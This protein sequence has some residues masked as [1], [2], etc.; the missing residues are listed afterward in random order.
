MNLKC[1]TKQI[2]AATVALF[3]LCAASR[4][5]A[6]TV[7]VTNNNDSGAGSLRQ[8]IASAASGDTIIFAANVTGTIT[9]NSGE[10]LVDKALTINGPGAATLG[11]SGNATSRIFSLTSPVTIARLTFRNGF[12]DANSPFGPGG[13]AV[14]NGDELTLNDCVFSSNKGSNGAVGNY[15]KVQV[16]RCTFSGNQAGDG[17]GLYNDVDSNATLVNCTFTN[18]SADAGGGIINFGTLQVTNGTF[19]GNSATHDGGAVSNSQANGGNATLDNCTFTNNTCPIGGALNSFTALTA[20]SCI[21]SANSASYGAALTLADG[22]ATLNDCDL[23]NNSVT[24]DGGAIATGNQTNAGSADQ[25][26]LNTCT[27]SGNSAVNGGAVSDNSDAVSVALNFCTVSNNR[28]TGYGGGLFAIH[29]WVVTASTLASNTAKAGGGIANGGDL[30]VNNCTLTGNSASGSDG[31]GGIA[32]YTDSSTVVGSCTIA[33]NSSSGSVGG[34]GIVNYGGAVGVANTII[35]LNSS[36]FPAPDYSGTVNTGGFNLIGKSN[37]SGGFTDVTDQ[38]GTIAA[39]L[40]PKLGLLQYNGGPTDTMAVL[41]GSPAID[42]GKKFSLADQRFFPRPFDNPAIANAVGGD[43]NDIGAFERQPPRLYISDVAIIEGDSGTTNANFTVNLFDGPDTAVSVS[44]ATANG[45]ALAGSDYNALNG[46]LTFNPG[47]SAKT[48]SVSVKGDTLDESDEN[49]FVNLS[50]PTNATIADTQ[51][52]CIIVDNDRAP[53]VA[54]NDVTITEGNS[55][56]KDTTFTITLSAVSGQTVTVNAIPSNGS[57]RSPFDYVAGGTRLIFAPGET[58]KTFSVPVKGDTLDEPDENFFVILSSPVN[59]SVGRGRGVGT[60]VDNDAGPTISIDDVRI[61]EGN[62]GQ[63]VASFRL[64]LSSPAGQVVRVNYSTDGGTATPGNDYIA[65]TNTQIAF[66]TGN[67]YAYAR[68]LIN[69]DVLNEPDETFNVNLSAPINAT[70][71]GAPPGSNQALGTI[72]NDDSAP[73]LAINDVQITEGNSGTKNLTFIVTLS[74]AS[75]QVVTVKYATTDGVARSISDYTAKTGTLTFAAGQTSKT[76]SI[77]VK[78]DT[79]V[80]GDETFF[81]L[82]SAAD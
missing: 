57:A 11:L 63:R 53:S 50:A 14:L 24:V 54:I 1:Y 21:F 33:N 23:L 61:G 71:A 70:I 68:V 16:N 5:H 44:F 75:G 4:A 48:V 3:L 69:G 31:G 51:G 66:T 56:T 74:K 58:V 28:A 38:K 59:C 30:T 49:F 15:F 32:S 18:N 29:T 73:S 64:K 20:N 7:T 40:D 43:G 41:S 36:S 81:V 22:T 78:G 52:R 67:L 25:L 47:E 6:A 46:T 60:I 65:V 13:N 77:A 55:G 17:G 42:K 19:N 8:T 2:L 37:G 26:T 34:G 62:V 79:V 35:A 9:L 72:L 82:L 39:P 27:L 80:E 76:I 12:S 45:T 10:I